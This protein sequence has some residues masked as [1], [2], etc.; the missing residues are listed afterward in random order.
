MTAIRGSSIREI[1]TASDF[2]IYSLTSSTVAPS[3]VKRRKGAQKK[4]GVSSVVQDFEFP[5]SSSYITYSNDQRLIIGVGNYPPQMRIW[6]LDELSML[7]Q[8]N[9]DSEAKKIL[10]LDDDYGKMVLMHYDRYIS[11][12]DKGKGHFRFRL[13]TYGRDMAY[14]DYSA[15][16]LFTL[17]APQLLRL[18]LE[19]GR[20]YAPLEL[21][22]CTESLCVDVAPE[23]K[24]IC[25]TTNSGLAHFVD[26]RSFEIVNTLNLVSV[27]E[28][29]VECGIESLCAKFH[30]SGMKIAIGCG[31]KLGYFDLRSKKPLSIVEFFSD[32][33]VIDVQFHEDSDSLFCT[34]SRNIKVFDITDD[35]DFKM[36]TSFKP[37]KPINNICMTGKDGLVFCSSQDTA[38]LGYYM[39][40]L[41]IAP[42][43]IQS[44]DLIVEELSQQTVVY[45]NFK[46][47]SHE[48]IIELGAESLLGTKLLRPYMNGFYMDVKLFNKLNSKTRLSFMEEYMRKKKEE[49][50][51]LDLPINE[52]EEDKELLENTQIDERFL[53]ALQNDEQFKDVKL[54]DIVSATFGEQTETDE[55]MADKVEANKRKQRSYGMLRSTTF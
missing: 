42:T 19:E 34:D 55:A 14:L 53:H 35:N 11:F 52:E 44:I 46:F 10:N 22:N 30:P 8:R 28:P 5:G 21:P 40:E 1:P 24:L 51:K 37:V 26:P 7:L 15:D 48:R 31:D 33:P 41:G 54:Q 36:R 3:F 6:E 32:L 4:T 47:V 16:L 45:D 18:S 50:L 23:H 38:V 12:H 2:K 9:M 27:L 49:E 17:A 13:P 43:W 29:S 25:V 39:P 20:F